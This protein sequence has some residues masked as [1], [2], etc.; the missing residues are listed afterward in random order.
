MAAYTPNY[1]LHQWVPE[2]T[3]LRTDFN[4]DFQKIDTALG[5]KCQMEAGTYT[6][7]GNNSQYISLSFQPR[8]VLVEQRYGSRSYNNAG[9]LQG[10]L[11]LSN[12]SLYGSANGW[13]VTAV[14]IS[15]S[16]FYVSGES[17]SSM[18]TSGQKYHYVAFR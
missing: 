12:S 16:G 8:A 10:G 1:Q 13:S 6:G 18:N 7:N 2:D 4:E 14:N 9:N 11:A 3:F 15:G 17:T 5:Q